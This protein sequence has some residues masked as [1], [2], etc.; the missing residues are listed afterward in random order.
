LGT[1]LLSAATNGERREISENDMSEAPDK[2]FL[3]DLKI[4]QMFRSGAHQVRAEEIHGLAASGWHT[5]SITMRLL[6]ESVPLA[7][8]IVGANVRELRWWTPVRPG[9]VLRLESEILEVQPWL[10]ERGLAKLRTATINQMGETVQVI[11]ANV[12]ARK[13]PSPRQDARPLTSG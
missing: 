12:I 13:R 7:G 3:E 6:V 8:G 11:V 10:P 4:G 2:L 1:T 9:D 5:A